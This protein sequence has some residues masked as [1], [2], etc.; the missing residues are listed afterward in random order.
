MAKQNSPAAKQATEVEETCPYCGTRY[1]YNLSAFEKTAPPCT[2][3]GMASHAWQAAVRRRPHHILTIGTAA[4]LLIILLLYGTDVMSIVRACPAAGWLA[5][6]SLAGH[7]LIAVWPSK[8]G[9]A[10]VTE[11]ASLAKSGN[12]VQVKTDESFLPPQA[13]VTSGLSWKQLTL[14]FVAGCLVGGIFWAEIARRSNGWILNP[15]VNNAVV[16]PGDSFT[17]YFSPRSSVDGQWTVSHGNVAIK[18]PKGREYEPP[19]LSLQTKTSRANQNADKDG[20]IRISSISDRSYTPWAAVQLPVEAEY[21]WRQLDLRVTLGISTLKHT[22]EKDNDGTYLLEDA[23]G[24]ESEDLSLMLSAPGAGARYR[25]YWM[26]GGVLG[27]CLFLM[28]IG[29]IPLAANRKTI[30][31]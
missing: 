11:I 14:F 16:G 4:V 19:G 22:G 8:K 25:R 15:S 26:I 13:M 20:K 12:L 3:C 6:L 18:L 9:P 28:T 23:N 10:T 31:A 17:M 1:R 21:G 29:L 7:F 27:S 24:T 30:V 5:T 2:S